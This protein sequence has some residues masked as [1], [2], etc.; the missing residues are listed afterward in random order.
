MLRAEAAENQRLAQASSYYFFPI[1]PLFHMIDRNILQGYT[2][3]D[4]WNT[5]GRRGTS[6]SKERDSTPTFYGFP[7]VEFSSVQRSANSHSLDPL[8][9]HEARSPC[10]PGEE[11]EDCYCGPRLP[12]S[13]CY[14]PPNWQD[15]GLLY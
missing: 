15:H 3:L 2:S 8:W 11:R 5:L 7:A 13:H 12:D 4:V 6:G 9:P 14:G 10:F 1:F